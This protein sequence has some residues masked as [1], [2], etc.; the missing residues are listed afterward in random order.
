[1]KAL[2]CDKCGRIF[3]PDG[4]IHRIYV[5]KVYKETF[6]VR[7]EAKWHLC[8]ECLESVKDFIEDGKDE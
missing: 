8:D 5:D 4:D 6:S 3:P 2:I 1:M 7:V